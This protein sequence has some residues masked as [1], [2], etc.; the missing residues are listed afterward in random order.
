MKKAEEN[1]TSLKEKVYVLGFL[2]TV[3]SQYYA[4]IYGVRM[5]LQ[6]VASKQDTYEQVTNI[7]LTN[8][9]KTNGRTAYFQ[10]PSSEALLP[11]G[12]RK[13]IFINN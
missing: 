12:T 5:E 10:P 3:I 9:E 8:L 7:R 4:T 1:K 2:V 13:R 6:V 11:S